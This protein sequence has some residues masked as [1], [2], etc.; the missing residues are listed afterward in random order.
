VE[1]QECKMEQEVQ[2]QMVEEVLQVMEQEL[3]VLEQLIQEE[4]Q[5]G[6]EK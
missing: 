4:D 3:L 1:E 2:H 6:L 5:V